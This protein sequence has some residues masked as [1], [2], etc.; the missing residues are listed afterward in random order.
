MHATALSG[1]AR[2]RRWWVPYVWMAAPVLV[3][4]YFYVFPFFNTVWLSLT[5]ARPLSA[6]GDFVGLENYLSVLSDERFWNATL[7]SVVYA[8]IV[9]PFMTVL[10]LLLA[11]LVRDRIPG[12]GVF[13]SL[14]YV[15]AVSSLVV[16]SLAWTAILK[17]DGAINNLLVGAGLVT[18]PIS[19]LT[20]RWLLIISAT[21]ITLWQGLPY[22]MI[23]YLAALANVD[24]SL[25]EAA[26]LDGAGPVRTFLSV[27]V[28]GVRVMMALV[29]TLSMIGS[30][31]IFTEVHLLSGGTGGIGRR[32]ETLTMYI[33]SIGMDPTYGS[34][35][36]GSAAAVCLFILT[37]GLIVMQRRLERNKEF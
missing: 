25:Y 27:T 36:A 1:V 20:D 24:R 19:F 18:E 15:P 2:F 9:V 6:S 30:L 17:D 5:D 22:Y 34:L 26:A 35:G 21:L 11:V 13:R 31:K 3:V 28:P 8:L 12:I 7:N 29:A 10:P 23:M 16:V 37:M 4:G 33:R 14:Y 32:S